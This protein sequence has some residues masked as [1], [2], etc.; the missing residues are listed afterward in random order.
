MIDKKPQQNDP[1]PLGEDMQ[2]WTHKE[3]GTI[4]ARPEKGIETIP[5]HGCGFPVTIPSEEVVKA[6]SRRIRNITPDHKRTKN[7]SK[8]PPSTHNW[9]GLKPQIDEKKPKF[10]T[11]F[12]S[13]IVKVGKTLTKHLTNGKILKA[14]VYVSSPSQILKVLDDNPEMQFELVMGHQRV[15]DFKQELTPEVVQRLIDYRN[16]KKRIC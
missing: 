14:V 5:C 11:I 7:H 1:L 16:N 3:C 10:S 6:R 2:N 8:Q 15:H 12:S 9:G 13:E 4:I